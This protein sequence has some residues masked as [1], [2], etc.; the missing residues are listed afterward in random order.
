MAEPARSRQAPGRPRPRRARPRPRRLGRAGHARRRA[1]RRRTSSGAAYST[2]TG[3]GASARA[4][5]TSKEARPSGQDSNR[6]WT[7]RAL[8]TSTCATARS[9]K[10]HLRVRLSTRA[11]LVPG[12]AIASGKPGTPAPLPRSAR[13]AA[14]RICSSSSPTSESARWSSITLR[15]S[16][17]AVGASG[18]STSRPMQLDAAGRWRRPDPPASASAPSRSSRPAG[19]RQRRLIA[20]VGHGSTHRA[21]SRRARSRAMY[22]AY[23]VHIASNRSAACPSIRRSS[24]PSSSGSTSLTSAV[25]RAIHW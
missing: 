8:R 6:A 24:L 3:S 15:G 5:T 17:T 4:V 2:T 13:V 14:V 1:S 11:T 23:R 9:R 21:G 12:R 25:P 20:I 16:R 19:G 18:S 10:A 7:T 22:A